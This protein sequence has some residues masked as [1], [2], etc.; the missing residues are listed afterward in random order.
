[1][2]NAECRM[3]NCA[4]QLKIKKVFSAQA[5]YSILLDKKSKSD[6]YPTNICSNS[7]SYIEHEATVS[8][9]DPNSLFYLMSRGIDENKATE[10]LV[11]GFLEAFTEELPLE[12]A[13]ELNQLLKGEV[14]KE[15]NI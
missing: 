11:M 12:Y 2:Q 7:S 13:V 15:C 1:M 4:R 9:I 10:L 14:I 6:T 3:Q 8:K 5:V